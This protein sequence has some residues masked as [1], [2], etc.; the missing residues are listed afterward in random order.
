M[1]ERDKDTEKEESGRESMNRGRRSMRGVW[2]R[3]SGV[4]GKTECKRE[5]NDGGRTEGKRR[6]GRDG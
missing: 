2:Q 3:N 6:G 5:K 4:S 1:N